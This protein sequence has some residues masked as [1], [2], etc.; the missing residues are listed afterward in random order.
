M[1][2]SVLRRRP[3]A[4][5]SPTSCRHRRIDVDVPPSRRTSSPRRSHRGP[6]GPRHHIAAGCTVVDAPHHP[7]AP[8]HRPRPGSTPFIASSSTPWASS[9]TRTSPWP[10]CTTSSNSTSR[11]SRSVQEGRGRGRGGA[12]DRWA[13]GRRRARLAV[14]E[15]VREIVA[16][17][18]VVDDVAR[19]HT[20]MSEIVRRHRLAA[21][22]RERRPVGVPQR[23]ALRHLL[24]GRRGGLRISE[25][26]SVIPRARRGALNVN[27]ATAF[28]ARAVRLARGLARD[29]DLHLV[30]VV[31]GRISNHCCV[32]PVGAHIRWRMMPIAVFSVSTGT[33]RVVQILAVVATPGPRP[34]SGTRKPQS[35]EPYPQDAD[36]GPAPRG[37]RDAAALVAAERDVRQRAHL[38]GL[39]H[40]ADDPERRTPA[41]PTATLT[42]TRSAPRPACAAEGTHWSDDRQ[43]ATRRVNSTSGPRTASAAD[44]P[45]E[46]PSRTLGRCCAENV[47]HVGDGTAVVA[48]AEPAHALVGG[49]MRP[50]IG[51]TRPVACRCSRSSHHPHRSRRHVHGESMSRLRAGERSQKSNGPR[52][53]KLKQ[54]A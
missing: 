46:A 22:R 12:G 15:E 33:R 10:S 30:V 38:G 26:V 27:F 32:D 23:A 43:S 41:T 24:E 9:S 51:L 40:D 54:S 35:G 21:R 18:R 49:A 31:V 4:A 17:K 14:A 39:L 50:R 7:Q 34:T 36:F 47:S 52:C 20:M 3:S 6:Y 44:G 28:A 13:R 5:S 37:R 1:R 11:S 45:A 8:Q 48:A 16:A 25:L 29:G 42:P 2:E 19:E 53:Q